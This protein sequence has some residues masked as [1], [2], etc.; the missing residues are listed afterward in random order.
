M[1]AARSILSILLILQSFLLETFFLIIM[2]RVIYRLIIIPF[3]YV[4]SIDGELPRRSLAA[5]LGEGRSYWEIALG[6]SN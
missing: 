4:L 6:T 5:E 3:Y 1:V 2:F